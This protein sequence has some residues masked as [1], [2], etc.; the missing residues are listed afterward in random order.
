MGKVASELLAR[1]L[2]DSGPSAVAADFTW[3]SAD[4]GVP[5]VDLEDKEG[6]RRFL[7]QHA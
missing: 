2:V 6:L 3:T 7:D 5:H 4:L 1:A